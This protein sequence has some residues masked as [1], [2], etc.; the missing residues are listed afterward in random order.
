MIVQKQYS[1]AMLCLLGGSLYASLPDVSPDDLLA[2]FVGQAPTSFDASMLVNLVESFTN[3]TAI[4]N[5]IT[6][7]RQ[8]SFLS[9]AQ[10]LQNYQTL[11]AQAQQQLALLQLQGLQDQADVQGQIDS[12]NNQGN[13]QIATL[14][15]SI[16]DLQAN[17]TNLQQNLATIANLTQV[18]VDNVNDI[19]SS[20]GDYK[21]ILQLDF[22][23]K[24]DGLLEQIRA[25]VGTIGVQ[26]PL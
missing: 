22:K 11:L 1:I 23:D 2:A 24:L 18:R 15:S 12:A 19:V 25:Y 10:Q 9:Y 16:A 13:S 17:I 20:Y 14:Q 6:Q 5:G 21:K 7:N 8:A 26:N 3:L 4:L